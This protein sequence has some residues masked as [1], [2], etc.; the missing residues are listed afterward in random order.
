[1]KERIYQFV[2]REHTV[3]TQFNNSLRHKHKHMMDSFWP[4]N[5]ATRR[6][7]VIDELM[8]GQKLANQILNVL[9]KPDDIGSESAENLVTKIVESFSNTISILK[10]DQVSVSQ[11]QTHHNSLVGSLS[12]DARKS[13]GFN[14]ESC[15]SSSTVKNRKGGYKRR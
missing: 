9:A 15:R 2:F 11:N 12:W 13:E 8:E 4:R 10:H 14:R 3:S 5:L 6:K 7:L 1:M